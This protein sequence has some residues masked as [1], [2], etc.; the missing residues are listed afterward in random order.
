MR[1]ASHDSA[2]EDAAGIYDKQGTLQACN[3]Y[4]RGQDTNALK[5]INETGRSTASLSRLLPESWG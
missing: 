3:F 5:P 1:K 2:S 4:V